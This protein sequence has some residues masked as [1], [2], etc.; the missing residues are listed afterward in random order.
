VSPTDVIS[1]ATATV[2][3]IALSASAPVARRATAA[4]QRQPT[5]RAQDSR[6]PTAVAGVPTAITPSLY[7]AP[8][9]A[10]AT[11]RAEPA[12]DRAARGRAPDKP[13]AGALS[14]P[15]RLPPQSP[16]PQP[17]ASAP[18]AGGGGGS[19][20]LLLLIGALAAGLTLFSFPV[21]HRRLPRTAFLKPRRVALA[22][23]HPG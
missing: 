20:P 4:H 16:F 12:G 22:V 2:A 14:R 1:S 13:A 18:G 10:L 11:P 6:G 8:S 15:Q 23:W 3:A 19:A 7:R 17:D 5:L 9:A 21:L